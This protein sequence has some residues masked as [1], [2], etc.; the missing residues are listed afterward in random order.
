MHSGVIHVG[1]NCGQERDQYAARHLN[2]VWIEPIPHV[3]EELRSNIAKKQNQTA[4]QYLVTQTDGE[5]HR[6]YIASNA[7]MSSSVLDLAQ[8]K[9]I[10]PEIDYVGSL[11]LVGQTLPTILEKEAVDL[12]LYD[13]LVIDTQGTELAI[14]RGS[15][16]I[17][18]RFS[19]IEVEVADFEAYR[20]CA[21]L[22]EVNL[23][24]RMNC[25]QP[26]ARPITARHP[27]GGKYYEAIYRRPH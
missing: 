11:D 26:W 20:G 3:Y 13:A 23:F 24:M 7:G 21:R 15:V 4:L 10:W 6:L 16:P 8:H 1:A 5:R 27:Q 18:S 2:V 25:F 12:S 19:L 17:L 9:D 22:K 14:L